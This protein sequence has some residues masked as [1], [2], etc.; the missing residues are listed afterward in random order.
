MPGGL[1]AGDGQQ[2]A[3][4]EPA[5][6]RGGAQRG[7]DRGGP[8]QRGELDCLGH[9]RPDPG[10][11]RGSGLGQPGPGAVTDRQERGFLSGHRLDLGRAG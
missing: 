3:V 4:T 9:L 7:I 5:R 11:T 6:Q 2:V 8:G 1:V 10:R